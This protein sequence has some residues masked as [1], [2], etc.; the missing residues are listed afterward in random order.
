[1]DNK[2]SFNPPKIIQEYSDADVNEGSPLALKCKLDLGYPKAR[3]LWYK[4]NTLIQPNGHYKLYYYGNGQHAL[5]VD[6]ATIEEDNGTFT[7]LAL[8]AAGRVQITADVF[9]HE[10]EVIDIPRDSPKVKHHD[11]VLKNKKTSSEIVT[12]NHNDDEAPTISRS[13]SPLQRSAVSD[14]EEQDNAK[15]FMDKFKNDRSSKL[16]E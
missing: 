6:E 14:N 8:N 4:E 9:V 12:M 3:I 15:R 10:K 11:R 7:C 1:L 16:L 2:R 13:I 5:H